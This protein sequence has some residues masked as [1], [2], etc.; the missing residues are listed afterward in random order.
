MACLDQQEEGCRQGLAVV[1]HLAYRMAEGAFLLLRQW[2]KHHPSLVVTYLES[3]AL[4]AESLELL[5]AAWGLLDLRRH[6]T[7]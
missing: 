7:R 4:V 2:I 5:A 1:A 3:R 6:K